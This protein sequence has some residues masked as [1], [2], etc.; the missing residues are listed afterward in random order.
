MFKKILLITSVFVLVFAVGA[1]NVFASQESGNTPT[2]AAM[3]CPA[4]YNEDADTWVSAYYCDGRLNA[5]DI[6]Q[7]V[8]VYDDYT[9]V[10]TWD[11]DGNPF[12]IDAVSGVSLWVIDWND[13]GQLALYVPESS[14]QAAVAAGTDTVIAE[15]NGVTLGYSAYGVLW[16]TGP[17]GYAFTWDAG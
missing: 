15:G 11:E 17:G 1:V 6:T 14:I 4:I 3:E 2:R 13:A 8:A 5:F 12:Y 16:V 9:S 10:Q 7:T